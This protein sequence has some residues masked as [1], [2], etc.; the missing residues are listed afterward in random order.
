MAALSLLD[1]PPVESGA[2]LR[3]YVPGIEPVP[4][5]GV[6]PCS[7]TGC[8]RL[9]TQVEPVGWRSI[10]WAATCDGHRLTDDPER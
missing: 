8:P 9:A 2:L 7:F 6:A 5:L 1:A 10:F 3:V 4:L